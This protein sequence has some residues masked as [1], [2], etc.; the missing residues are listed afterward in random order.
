MNTKVLET[1]GLTPGEIKVYIALVRLGETT[2]GPIIEESKVSVSKVYLI[3][4]RLSRK[5]LAS[6]IIKQKTKYF[7][8][9]DPTRLQAYLKEKEE[10]LKNQEKELN[11]LIPELELAKNSATT[12]ETAQVYDGMRGL[13]T[14]R[15]R[16]LKIMKEGDEMWIIGISQTPYEGSMTPF[17]RDFHKRRYTKK[18]KCKYLYN[19]YAK[20]PYGKISEKYPLSEVKYMPEGLVTHAW[21]EIYAD[22]VTIGI[23]KGKSFSVVIINQEVANSFRI[24][25]EMLWKSSKKQN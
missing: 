6:H 19:E 22:T 11:K 5:G 25:A 18:I 3:L 8:A 20:E 24:Y 17:F 7:K 4:D 23:N 16:S 14:A 12:S 10:E 21:I 2:S 15:E 1:L 13:Q 9:A